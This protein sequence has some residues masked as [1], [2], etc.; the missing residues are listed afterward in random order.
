M[1]LVSDGVSG[2]ATGQGIDAA[3]VLEGACHVDVPESVPHGWSRQ[4]VQARVLERVLGKAIGGDVAVVE[5]VKYIY[6]GM[7]FFCEEGTKLGIALTWLVLT[8]L[9]VSVGCHV[10]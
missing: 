8:N 3:T 4:A 5:S 7:S 6:F 10:P 2:P 9:S 1:Y